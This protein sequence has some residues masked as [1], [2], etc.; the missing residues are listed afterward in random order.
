MGKIRADFDATEL[1][2]SFGYDPSKALIGN[3]GRWYTPTGG[4]VGKTKIVVMPRDDMKK[5]FEAPKGAK[6][7]ESWEFKKLQFEARKVKNA[8]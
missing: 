5:P 1:Y 7:I 2:I 6:R 4:T 8:L 3:G